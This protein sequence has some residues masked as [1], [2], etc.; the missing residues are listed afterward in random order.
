M[1]KF[2]DIHKGETCLLVGNGPNLLDTPPEWFGFPSF[3]LNTIFYYEGWKPTYFVA[4]DEGVYETFG[5][6]VNEKYKG[7]PKFVSS[8]TLDCWQGEDVYHFQKVTG[9][10]RLPSRENVF[11]S[12]T[13]HNVMNAAMIL[14]WHMGFTTMLI[15]GM[16]QKP[17]RGE[18][19]KHFWGTFEPQPE[20]QVDTHWNIGNKNI[21]RAM[22]DRVKVLNISPNTYVPEDVIPRDNWMKYTKVTTK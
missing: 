20:S 6:T 19:K 21:I 5:E 4:V 14:A 8:P 22:G 18:L 10:I 3:G 11:K 13:Y 17:G 12:L 15:I 7:I 9:D 1:N 16:E 2:Y